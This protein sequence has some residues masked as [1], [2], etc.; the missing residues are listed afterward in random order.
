MVNGV[1]GLMTSEH[2]FRSSAFVTV[3]VTAL[4]EEDVVG[5]VLNDIAVT[6]RSHLERFEIIAIDDGSTDATGT[7]MDAFAGTN[8]ECRVIH[9]PSNQGIG[10][11][12]KQALAEA[13]GQ[14]YMLLCGDGG[15]PAS[16]LPP[17]FEKIG[18]ADIVV[19]FMLN[20]RQ[21]KTPM[22][23]A[24]SKAYTFLLNL[25][26]GLRLRYYNGLPVHRVDLLRPLDITSDGFGF[27]AEILV[28]LIQSG[29]SFV[30]VGVLGAEKTN[31]SSAIRIANFVSVGRTFVT[32]V[33]SVREYLRTAK[34]RG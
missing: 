8:S 3:A 27:Q 16:S 4:N 26:F 5:D 9:N 23:F 18:K 1:G 30:E 29:R 24:L 6:C 31:R 2:A 32:L 11:A 10:S 34:L 13:K 25:I 22:R 19:P 12:Y 15:L 28:K 33:S 7:I 20:L 21:I 17:I 14:Y